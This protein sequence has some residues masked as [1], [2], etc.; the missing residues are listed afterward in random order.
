[1]QTDHPLWEFSFAGEPIFVVCKNPA[2]T[3]RRSRWASTFT[4]T[5]QPR[6]VFDFLKDSAQAEIAIRAVRK[7]LSVYDRSTPSPCLGRYGD[8]DN[9]EADQ[10]FLSDDDQPMGCPYRHLGTADKE[11]K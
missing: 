11:K 10:Y 1:M 9:R 7:R 2:H 3:R 4:M 8:L 5:F 6:W